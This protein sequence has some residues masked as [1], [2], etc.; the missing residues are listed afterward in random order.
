MF[1]DVVH[2]LLYTSGFT[3]YTLIV[4]TDSK[5]VGSMRLIY[6]KMAAF[7]AITQVD[8]DLH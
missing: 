7:S 1:K 2:R 8:L 5:L 4:K 6:Q 3:L